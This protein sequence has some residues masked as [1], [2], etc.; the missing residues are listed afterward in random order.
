MFLKSIEIRGFKSFADKTELEFKKGITAV[1]G[2]NGSGK[3]NISDAVRWVLGEQ[4]VKSLRGDKMSDVIFAGTQFRK[5]VGLAQVSLVLDN[6]QKELDIDYSDVKITRRLYRS[7]ESEYFINNTKCRLKDIQELFMDTG[8]GKEG[9]SLIGQGKIDAILNGKPE[10]RRKLME[11]AAGIV[12]FK[13]RKIEAERR[14]EYTEQNLVRINDILSTYSERL[15]PLRNEMEKAKKFLKLSSELKNM[16][17]NLLIDSI[18]KVEQKILNVKNEIDEANNLINSHIEEKDNLKHEKIEIEKEIEDFDTKI[19]IEKQKYFDIKEMNQGI[20]SDIKL[21]QEKIKNLSETIEKYDDELNNINN[22]KE[23][24]K[25]NYDVESSTLSE[26]QTYQNKLYQQIKDF[27]QKVDVLSTSIAKE[28]NMLDRFKNKKVLLESELSKHNSDI[29]LLNKDIEMLVSRK[30]KLEIDMNGYSNKLKI[31][32]ST[33]KNI[34]VEIDNISKTIDE[35][36]TT[37]DLN[38]NNLSKYRRELSKKQKSNV[39]LNKEF[40]RIEA[41]HSVLV[42]LNNQYE[43]YTRAVKQLMQHVNKGYVAGTK[44]KTFVLGEVIAVDK[45]YETAIEIALGAAISNIITDDDDVA[46]KLISYLKNRNLGRAT[47]L[48]LNII[49]G[50]KIN[51]SGSVIKHNG[52]IGIASDLI[53]YDKK[54]VKA[55]EYV[56]GKVI[57]VNNMDNALEFAKSANYQYKIVTLG[58]ELIN[59]GGSLT[60]GSVYKKN[61]NVFSRKREIAY[62]ENQK[63]IISNKLNDI[64]Q[65]IIKYNNLISKLDEE[66]LNLKDEIHFQNIELTKTQ[67]KLTAIEQDNSNI[68]NLLMD[69]R[70][71]MKSINNEIHKNKRAISSINVEIKNKNLISDELKEKI[72][73]LELQLK[74]R[75]NNI[76]SIKNDLTGIKIKKAKCDESVINKKQNIKRIENEILEY[77]TKYQKLIEEIHNSI[78][79]KDMCIKELGEKKIK[80]MDTI[81]VIKDYEEKFE[82]HD[83]QRL[84]LKEKAN[85][86]YEKLDKILAVIKNHENHLYKLQLNLTRFESEKEMLFSKLNNEMELTYAEALDLKKDIKDFNRLKLDISK[87]KK[88]ISDMGFVNVGAIEEYKEVNEKHKFLSE[89][90][91]DL[92][93]SKME[94]LDIINEM[95]E[96][97]KVVFKQNFEKLRKY[98]DETFKELFKGG[99]A[100]LILSDGDE[101]NSNIEISV[102]P[103]GK[104]LQ[105]INLMSGGEKVLSAIALL[106]AILKMKPTPFCILDEIEAALDDANVY[107]YA[108]FLR[109]FSGDIQFIVITHRKGTMEASDVLY[110]VTME[111]KGVSKIVSV[112]LAEQLIS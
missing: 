67:A 94:I 51:N 42:N 78:K 3:S 70:K 80:H 89:Q 79:I 112:D 82:S 71:E 103:P 15:E 105:N 63:V 77:N 99:S 12:K 107:R 19:S 88:M 50:R 20:L 104:K 108:Q 87:T 27:E 35:I 95:T 98:F 17:V 34:K 4:S 91:E 73:N 13:T 93:T 59:P 90:R 76:E 29:T 111:E 37:I 5:P 60:G 36:Q 109:K 7:G 44:N 24:I 43:G 30:Q 6:V 75:L 14:L 16:E 85:V 62:L 49:Q 48:P 64:K 106:F 18:E 28:N 68:N 110:G 38:N 11:E 97:M 22:K 81:Q 102:Q 21:L 57:I 47:F 58:G 53:K 41:N 61:T 56:L 54:F 83:M 45:E 55:I 25:K 65:E 32:L 46:K 52:V 69:I 96:K 8:I 84:K 33:K 74:D 40:Q 23:I 100:D 31:N 86:N 66:N 101:L 1:V 2:P 9:Y 10:D 92:I 39:D 72:E 26:L